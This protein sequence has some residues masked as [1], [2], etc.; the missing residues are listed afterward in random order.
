MLPGQEFL[1]LWSLE[2]ERFTQGQEAVSEFPTT[3]SYPNRD[4]SF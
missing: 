3:D 4:N 1:L 2:T